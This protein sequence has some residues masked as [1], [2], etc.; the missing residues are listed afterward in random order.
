MPIKAGATKAREEVVEPVMVQVLSPALQRRALLQRRDKTQGVVLEGFRAV[1]AQKSR[2][3]VEHFRQK[4]VN[5]G[6][7]QLG[8]TD[9]PLGGI[10]DPKFVVQSLQQKVASKVGHPGKWK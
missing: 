6:C 3:F 10:H 1:L 2:R 7:A 8:L 5:R 4:R 9:A